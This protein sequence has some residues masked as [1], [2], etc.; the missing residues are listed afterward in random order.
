M[1]LCTSKIFICDLTE[2]KSQA[3]STL[4]WLKLLLTK[5]IYNQTNDYHMN[6]YGF[7]CA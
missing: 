4:H 5:Q 3:F 7:L 6:N 2:Y 1:K